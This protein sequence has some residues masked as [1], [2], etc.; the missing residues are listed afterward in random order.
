M[1]KR[2]L[3]LTLKK[4][5]FDEIFIKKEKDTEFREYKPYWTKRLET[6]C[7]L[8]VDFD[9]IHFRNGYKKDSRFGITKHYGTYITTWNGKKAYALKLGKILK[10]Q[11]GELQGK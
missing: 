7:G 9:E 11:L 3:Y 10:V 1:K 8:F 4:K 2:I 5:Y 6:P